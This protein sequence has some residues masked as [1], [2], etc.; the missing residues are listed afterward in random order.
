MVEARRALIGGGVE[1]ADWRGNI[2]AP[3]GQ[4]GHEGPGLRTGLGKQRL[5]GVALWSPTVDRTLGTTLTAPPALEA[6]FNSRA[7][8]MRE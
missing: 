7:P 1:S 3:I 4:R 8:E 6:L 5:A 2:R